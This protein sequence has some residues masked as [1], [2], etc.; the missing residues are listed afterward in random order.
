MRHVAREE[1]AGAGPAHGNLVADLEDDL[2]GQYPGDL[3]A[4]AVQME[5]A[6]S[7][8][9]KIERRARMTA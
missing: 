6:R 7:G 9:K 2:A 5:E 1:R 4:V 3:V 8:S